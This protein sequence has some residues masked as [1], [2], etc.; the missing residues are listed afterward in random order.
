MI[1]WIM[2]VTKQFPVL[3]VFHDICIFLHAMEANED[4]KL[5]T[6]IVC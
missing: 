4:H 3:I 2:S 1:T 5:V 6:I